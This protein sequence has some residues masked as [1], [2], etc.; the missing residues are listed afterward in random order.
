V[1][2]IAGTTPDQSLQKSLNR[3]GDS[4]VYR[5]LLDVLVAEIGLQ[6]PG[7]VAVI[8]KLVAARMPQRM[9]VDVNPASGKRARPA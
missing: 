3:V 8:G 6:Q 9:S 4:S 1:W 5:R 7:V 2:R